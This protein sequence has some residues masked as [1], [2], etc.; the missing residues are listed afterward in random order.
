[1]H[2]EYSLLCSVV[3]QYISI[4]AANYELKAEVYL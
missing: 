2:I 4:P 1:M 3:Y